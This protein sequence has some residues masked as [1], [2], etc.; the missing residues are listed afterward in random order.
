MRTIDSRV[1][2]TR[3]Y[4]GEDGESHRQTVTHA[5]RFLPLVSRSP[6]EPQA[7]SR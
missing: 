7:G 6:I 5:D 4:T 2:P 1:E 3:R